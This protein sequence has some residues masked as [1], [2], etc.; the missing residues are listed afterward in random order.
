[1][2]PK[3]FSL[4]PKPPQHF[5]HPPRFG[6]EALI[7]GPPQTCVYPDVCL[8]IAH[9][10]GKVPSLGTRGLVDTQLYLPL[11]PQGICRA[12]GADALCI[13]QTPCPEKRDFT[14]YMGNP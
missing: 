7:L 12:E 2:H 13:C 6:P 11:S 14:R 10:S 3:C 4:E 9:L 5:S 1:M 8:R